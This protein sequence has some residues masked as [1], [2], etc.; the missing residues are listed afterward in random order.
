MKQPTL[1]S[2]SV[3]KSEDFTVKQLSLLLAPPLLLAS[4]YLAYNWL[5]DLLG[6]KTGYFGGFLF[7]WISWCLLF[8]LW[9]LGPQGFYNLFRDVRPRLGRPGQWHTGGGPLAWTLCRNLSGQV[10]A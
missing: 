5:V 6:Q 2:K 9:V 3:V 8:P 1:S 10:M 4:T 7:Y